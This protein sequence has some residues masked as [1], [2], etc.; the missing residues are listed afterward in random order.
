[1]AAFT[2][3]GVAVTSAT[4]V[5]F[6]HP[7]SDPIEVLS[8]IGGFLATLLSLFGV[9]LSTLAVNITANVVGTAN[10]LVNLNP[11]IFSFR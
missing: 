6:G 11:R 9:L 7:V 10:S 5:I 2:F 1:M 3:I 4:V 8:L